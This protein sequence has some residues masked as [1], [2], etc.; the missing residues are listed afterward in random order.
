[1]HLSHSSR[2]TF[3]RCRQSFYLSR[4]KHI[5]IRN[6]MLP[7]PVKLGAIWDKYMES[8][9]LGVKFMDKFWSMIDEYGIESDMDVAKIYALIQAHRKLEMEPQYET[10]DGGM[11]RGC[12]HRFEFT[13]DGD[14]TVIGYIDRAYSDHI[15][16]TKLTARPDFYFQI[17]NITS[18]IGT[19]F[20]SNPEYKYAVIESTR[21]PGLRTGAG[22]YSDES[23]DAYRDR[24]I[25]EI[26]SKPSYYFLGFNRDTRTFGKKFWRGEFDMEEL[27]R[28]Y[29]Y[30]NQEIC[31]AME[32]GDGAFYKNRKACYVP[33]PCFYLNICDTGVCSESIYEVKEPNIIK[34]KEVTE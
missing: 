30:V 16:E 13:E 2:E 5:S 34:D 20:L 3:I 21:V 24:I 19:Y 33:G 22:K 9:Y 25:S 8:R 1:M 4:I 27:M 17:H 15:V 32:D 12:Q 11:F 26:I 31:R 6:S 14:F 29:F 23:P 7:L 10:A 28:D 18:Q